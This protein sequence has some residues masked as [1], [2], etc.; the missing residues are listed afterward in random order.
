MEVWQVAHRLV[1]EIY[2]LSESFPAAERLGLTIQM[3]RSSVSIPANIAEGFARRSK[4][5]KLNFFNIARGSLAETTYYLILARDLKYLSGIDPLL[6]RCD[7]ISRMLHNLSAR[8][9]AV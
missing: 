3:R 2:R 6:D 8:V 1:L 7:H 4:K 5:E 9:R